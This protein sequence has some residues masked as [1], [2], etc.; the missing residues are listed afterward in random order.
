MRGMAV[1]LRSQAAPASTFAAR[2]RRRLH[3]VMSADEAA[4]A[5][6][7]TSSLRR[8]GDKRTIMRLL[9]RAAAAGHAAAAC[10]LGGELCLRGRLQEGHA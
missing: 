4:A 3:P 2:V 1:W 8:P 7:R 5:Y 6:W 10:E 9:R